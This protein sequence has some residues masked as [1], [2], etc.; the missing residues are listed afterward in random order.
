MP[1]P[2]G[3]VYIVRRLPGVLLPS[4]AAYLALIRILQRGSQSQAR[5]RWLAV[6]AAVVAQPI[7]SGLRGLYAEIS[8]RRDARRR[9]AVEISR[10]PDRYGGLGLDILKAMGKALTLGY[11]AQSF[12]QWFKQYGNTYML[13][14]LYEDRLQIVTSEPQYVKAVL[15]T[16]FDNYWKGPVDNYRGLSLLGTGVFNSDGEMWKFHRS[17]TRPYFSRDR[18]TDFDIFDKHAKDVLDLASARLREGYPVDIQDVAARFTLDSATA[19]LFG[20]SVD[21]ISAG[22]AYPESAAHLTS[23]AFLNHPSNSFVTAFIEGQ[24]LHVD[25]SRFGSKWQLGEFWKDLIQPHR[26]VIDK[27]IEPIIQRAL[28]EKLRRAAAST[29]ANTD[30]DK[31]VETLLGHLLKSTEDKAIIRDEILNMLVAGR[32]T[33]SATITFAIYMLA[34]HPDKARRLREEI[35]DRVGP[36]RRPTHDDVKNMPYLRAF[37]NETLRLYPPVPVDSRTSKNATTWP[38]TTPG[39]PPLYVPANTKIIYTVFL[40]HRRKDLWGPDALEFDPDR[41]IDDRLGKYLT[42]NPYIFLPFNAGP[43]ICLGQQFAYQETSF[44]LIRLLQRFCAIHLA[45]DAQPESS[46]PPPHWKLSELKKQE[47][48]TYGTSLTMYA[49]DGVWVRMDTA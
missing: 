12:H 39:G 25:R 49:K 13:T 2:P 47:K 40:M 1:V 23:P 7:L 24:H 42:P 43:R 9:G 44:F 35:L 26:E 5:I 32:D 37:I 14:M 20:D 18:V 29:E 48:I 45:P 46:K 10:V 19:F 31:E 36:S 22:L 6:V 4:A 17:M 3:I 34:E 28:S 16:E 27:F 15:A 11:P 8:A 21:S 33:T 38:S 30:A 41:F